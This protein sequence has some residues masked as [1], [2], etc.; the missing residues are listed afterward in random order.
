MLPGTEHLPPC[1]VFE[2]GE[3]TLAQRLGGRAMNPVE[4]LA[5]VHSVGSLQPGRLRFERS[6]LCRSWRRSVICTDRRLRT[7]TWIRHTSSGHRLISAG[8]SQILTSPRDSAIHFRFTRERQRATRRQRSDRPLTRA[9][10]R[11][12][13]TDLRTCGPSVCSRSKSS[14]VRSPRAHSPRL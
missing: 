3:F 6:A 8:S 10:P 1:L 12:W 4:K 13:Q 11:H 7:G 5:I 9:R 14:P 2:A